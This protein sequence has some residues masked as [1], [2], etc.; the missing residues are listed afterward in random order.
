MDA[1]TPERADLESDTQGTKIIACAPV[2]EGMLPHPP[3]DVEP[4]VL[5]FGL[6]VNPK[7]LECILQETIDAVAAE[8]DTILLGYGLCSQTAVG[9]QANDCTLVVPRVDDCV[10]TFLGSG[11]AYQMQFRAEPGTCH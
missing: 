1:K 2:I 3:M 8:A 5:N 6:H 10:A 7:E 9:L 11:L 4:R